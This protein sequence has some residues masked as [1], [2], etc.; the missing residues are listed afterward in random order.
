MLVFWKLKL[1]LFAVPK[2]GTTALESALSSD[3]DAAILNPPGLK[4]CTVRKYRKE[5]ATFFEQ[6]GRRP[7][8]SVAVMRE[9]VEWLGSWFR[10]R[11]RDS[12]NGHENSTAQMTFDSFVEG[13]LADNAPPA[14]KVGSQATFL[15]GGVDHL[16][17][18]DDQAGLLAFLENRLERKI[19]LKRENVSPAADLALSDGIRDRL[20]IERRDD[21]ELWHRLITS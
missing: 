17:R 18:Y 15:A 6:G 1:V 10:Y 8:A 7:L 13:Y 19:N 20:M 11:A 14:C 16:F 4:H 5:L 21:F 2:T 12:L 9:P 3:A